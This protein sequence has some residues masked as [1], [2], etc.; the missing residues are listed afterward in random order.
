MSVAGPF[1]SRSHRSW[2][3]GFWQWV[4]GERIA[5]LRSVMAPELDLH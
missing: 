2:G 4:Y 3:E 1:P 5:G